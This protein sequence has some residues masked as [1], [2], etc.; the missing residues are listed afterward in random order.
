M[1]QPGV[2][3]VMCAYN[4]YLGQVCLVNDYYLLD[5]VK[6]E[7][8]EIEIRYCCQNSEKYSLTSGL[9]RTLTMTALSMRSKMLM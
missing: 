9:F 6:N 2:T 1:T 4:A 3:G 7:F 8:Y 5:A